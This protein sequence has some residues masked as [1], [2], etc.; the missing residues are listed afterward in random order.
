MYYKVLLKWTQQSL[1]DFHSSVQVCSVRIFSPSGP[2]P[3]EYYRLL[4]NLGYH[5]SYRYQ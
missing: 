5:L 2:P 3:I 1:I 4:T